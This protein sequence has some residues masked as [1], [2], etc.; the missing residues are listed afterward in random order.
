MEE[1][2]KLSIFKTRQ[3]KLPKDNIPLLETEPPISLSEKRTSIS[4][5]FAKQK[6]GT[7]STD[8]NIPKKPNFIDK[9]L[10]KINRTS[11]SS[12]VDNTQ[13]VPKN[14]QEVPKKVALRQTNL[15]LFFPS[16]KLFCSP[17]IKVVIENR[18][19]NKK[20][21]SK[22]PQTSFQSF[23]TLEK[24]LDHKDSEEDY[25]KLSKQ[26][27]EL[28]NS[29]V[30]SNLCDEELTRNELNMRH[31]TFRNLKNNNT[32]QTKEDVEEEKKRMVAKALKDKRRE[33][34]EKKKKKGA[35]QNFDS[36]KLAQERN[37]MLRLFRKTM[38]ESSKT[39]EKV[40]I[41]ER[42]HFIIFFI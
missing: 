25:S 14:T 18:Q 36:E 39:R 11:K 40:R 41:L 28:N 4:K 29:R 3:E 32:K 31:E 13:E 33:E 16:P 35:A 12:S 6:I 19:K 8:F 1:T 17:D 26:L 24:K 9:M 30:F 22:K 23:K 37:R 21:F 38:G 34:A 20:N 27:A 5:I 42:L 10:E 2:N 15:D 7:F